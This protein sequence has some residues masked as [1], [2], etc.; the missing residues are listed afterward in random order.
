MHHAQID[1]GPECLERCFMGALHVAVHAQP[2]VDIDAA[3]DVTE[4]PARVVRDGHAAIENP[5]VGT[6]VPA[7]AVFHFE[8]F[9]SMECARS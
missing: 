5:A 3:P 4:K 8:R 7:Q 9:A 2:L 6:I 1:M